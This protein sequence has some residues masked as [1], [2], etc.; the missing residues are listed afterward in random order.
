MY[1]ATKIGFSFNWA[2]FGVGFIKV[3]FSTTFY[4]LFKR[5]WGIAGIAAIGEIISL[6]L[7]F[8]TIPIFKLAGL[9]VLLSTVVGIAIGFERLRG[10]FL[11]KKGY[12]LVLEQYSNSPEQ[13]INEYIK[14]SNK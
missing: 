12:R 4:P 10:V 1:E 6:T 11:I 7:L 14:N 3:P 8:Q 5:E 13:A 2:S 9:V